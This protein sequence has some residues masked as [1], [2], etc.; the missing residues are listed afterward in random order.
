MAATQYLFFS[1]VLLGEASAVLFA[2][3]LAVVA[4]FDSFSL[5]G[6]ALLVILAIN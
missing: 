6:D 3:R 4:S 1:D 2:T 5:E